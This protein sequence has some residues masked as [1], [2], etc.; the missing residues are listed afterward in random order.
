MPEPLLRLDDLSIAFDG[1]NVVDKLSLTVGRGETLA[2]V[3]ESG[4][5]KSVSALGAM[6]LLPSNAR[7]TGERRLGDTDLATLSA[8]GWRGLRGGQVGFIFQ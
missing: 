5:G 6:N 3:G 2:L 4:S 1:I 8:R 7:V